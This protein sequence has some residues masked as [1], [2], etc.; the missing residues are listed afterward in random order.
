MEHYSRKQ[1]RYI[2]ERSRENELVVAS[3]GKA[4]D[5]ATKA[6]HIMKVYPHS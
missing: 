6:V 3:A 5:L 1:S 2:T 4:K